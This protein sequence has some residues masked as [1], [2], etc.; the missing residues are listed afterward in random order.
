MESYQPSSEIPGSA[1]SVTGGASVCV[2]CAE[3]SVTACSV[4]GVASVCVGSGVVSA[5]VSMIKPGPPV[6]S[7]CLAPFSTMAQPP[8]P[9]TRSR[10][11]VRQ[12][13]F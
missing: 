13:S 9:R 7:A 1:G 4:A 8:R 10:V 5:R 12:T 2:G 11:S 6:V 3:V